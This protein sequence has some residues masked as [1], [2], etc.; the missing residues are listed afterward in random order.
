MLIFWSIAVIASLFNFVIE[1]SVGHLQRLRSLPFSMQIILSPLPLFIIWFLLHKYR[2]QLTNFT[3]L[4]P[5]P[6]FI[7]YMLLGFLF[8][9]VLGLNSTICYGICGTDTGQSGVLGADI[10]PNPF[11]N[12]L[13]YLGPYGGVLLAYYL[14]RKFY[15]FGYQFVFWMSSIYFA[16]TEQG[17]MPIL[18]LI[19]G[20]ILSLFTIIFLIAVHGIFFASVWLIMPKEQLPPGS[21]KPKLLGYTLGLVLPFILFFACAT[22][23]YW[24]LDTIFGTNFSNK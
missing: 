12:S 10:H 20:N 18:M 23:Y 24:T 8:S 13:L 6:S 9:V 21:R 22:I 11:I 7:K 14:L 4:I 2:Q 5:I 16:I 1:D 15:E 19:S 17:F 3:S